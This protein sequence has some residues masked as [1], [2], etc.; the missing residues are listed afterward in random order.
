M[1]NLQLKWD[2]ILL[3]GWEQDK[4][5]GW[6]VFKFN[7]EFIKDTNE[8]IQKLKDAKLKRCFVN[9]R[10]DFKKPVRAFFFDCCK[11][12]NNLLFS[13]EPAVSFALS[14]DDFDWISE[15]DRRIAHSKHQKRSRKKRLKGRSQIVGMCGGR[16]NHESQWNL[17]K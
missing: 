11:K 6:C 5:L 14:M 10:I 1:D 2:L 8:A 7:G 4:N 3:K 16:L 9:G 13:G 17:T 15:Y 12:L